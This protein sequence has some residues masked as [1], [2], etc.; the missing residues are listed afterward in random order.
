MSSPLPL[1]ACASVYGFLRISRA[2]SHLTNNVFLGSP[3]DLQPLTSARFTRVGIC[4]RRKGQPFL[5]S[6]H[7]LRGKNQLVQSDSRKS[8]H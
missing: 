1:G 3:A 7:D 4:D 2:L 6:F 5:Y 8:D